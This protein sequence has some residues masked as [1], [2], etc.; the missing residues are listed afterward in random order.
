MM[1]SSC[2]VSV[3]CGVLMV[4]SFQSAAAHSIRLWSH[5]RFDDDDVRGRLSG[6]KPQ[7]KLLLERHKN[8]GSPWRIREQ[9]RRVRRGNGTVERKLESDVEQTLQAGAVGDRSV[10][11]RIEKQHE[12]VHRYRQRVIHAIVT[13]RLE[14]S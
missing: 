1:A 4:W 6:F 14:P 9:R 12:R 3:G 11:D 2:G 13:A 8:G 10:E 5:Y 7:P